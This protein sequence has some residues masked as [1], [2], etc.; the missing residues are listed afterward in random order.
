LSFLAQIVVSGLTLGSIYALVGIGFV[1]VYKASRTLNFAHGDLL[2]LGAILALFL[3]GDL[4]VPYW[5]T[6]AIVLLVMGGVG[7]VVER[8]VY[9]PLAQA[10]QF[11][12]ILGTVAVGAMI[13]SGVRIHAE[14][15][16]SYFPAFLPT[17]PVSLLGVSA[18][19]LQ[20]GII[21]ISIGLAV[22]FTLF[23]RYTTLGKAMRAVSE[24]PDAASLVGIKVHRTYALVWGLSAAFAAAAG[25][26]VAPLLLITPD[27]GTIANKAFIGAILG[28]FTSVWGTVL[29]GLLLGVVENLIGVYIS[30]AYKDVI[31]FLLLLAI[32]VVRPT[33]IFGRAQLRKV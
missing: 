31:S 10:P 26:L 13:R 23:F 14:Q 21:G 11:T 5:L 29:G 6:F 7:L 2:M 33:G 17:E 12:V 32:L 28:G 20:L 19:P 1:I 18:T 8:A 4:A 15:Q 30:T 25:I 16:L 24:N 27:M 3:H 22:A 9:R